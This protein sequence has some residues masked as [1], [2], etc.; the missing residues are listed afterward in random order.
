M[1]G[2][3]HQPDTVASISCRSSTLLSCVR[4]SPRKRGPSGSFH[5][6]LDSRLRGNERI[7][8]RIAE[9]SRRKSPGFVLVHRPS[10]PGNKLGNPRDRVRFG[11]ERRVALVGH[12][13]RLERG[14]PCAH[15]L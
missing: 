11:E 2:G 14:S 10:T 3:S 5:Y 4:S 15:G 1:H 12:F 7:L 6:V 9:L 8:G 13:E